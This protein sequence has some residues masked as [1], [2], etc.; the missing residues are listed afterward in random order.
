MIASSP[1]NVERLVIELANHPD[2]SFVTSLLDGFKNGF[3]KGILTPPDKTFECKNLLSAKNNPDFVSQ[4]LDKEV[5]L[6][7][8]LGGYTAPPFTDDYR[9]SPIGVA[10]HKF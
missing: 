5:Q 2:K 8:M 6:G 1:V 9:V 7:Y 10:Q 4:Q 3:N